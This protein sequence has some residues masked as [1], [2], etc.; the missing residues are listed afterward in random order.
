MSHPNLMD[1]QHPLASLLEQEEES[2]EGAPQQ[3]NSHP[4]TDLAALAETLPYH[5]HYLPAYEDYSRNMYD[6]P[7]SAGIM[8]DIWQP[9]LGF[10][11]HYTGNRNEVVSLTDHAIL[12][13]P[14]DDFWQDPATTTGYPSLSSHMVAPQSY[15][16]SEYG[17]TLP[18]STQEASAV[19]LWTTFQPYQQPVG[20]PEFTQRHEPQLSSQL[21]LDP[22]SFDPQYG[23]L[24][25]IY[26]SAHF[27]QSNTGL[28]P[29]TSP[30]Y[31]ASEFGPNVYYQTSLDPQ[32]ATQLQN[33]SNTLPPRQSDDVLLPAYANV[34]P[35]SSNVV[36]SLDATFGLPL[37]FLPEYLNEPSYH[38]LP[39]IQ[40]SPEVSQ[41]HS[42]SLDGPH[43]M[44]LTSPSHTHTTIN[45]TSGKR[46]CA[47]IAD[48]EHYI[49]PEIGAKRARMSTISDQEHNISQKATNRPLETGVDLD[50]IQFY[51]NPVAEK[52]DNK[53][54]KW[55]HVVQHKTDIA[56]FGCWLRKGRVGVLFC[57]IFHDLLLTR[58][59]CA[60]SGSGAC[61]SCRI[62]LRRFAHCTSVPKFTCDVRTNI[63]EILLSLPKLGIF[64][65]AGYQV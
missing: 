14:P 60:R 20:M 19:P 15:Q 3:S 22:N 21:S 55:S 25:N 27:Q 24:D 65:D 54:R 31:I 1:P 50:K 48:Q 61:E 58:I 63:S 45:E 33:S 8:D 32:G 37:P 56:C 42:Q 4:T 9:P 18:R 51:Q 44:I 30:L 36:A 6:L 47:F 62:I 35:A 38:M 40:P 34:P 13:D 39:Y 11:E 7:A 53:N 29:L 23:D 41:L 17:M 49:S 5:L 12:A 52:E 16:I 26:H 64:S 28:M 57:I 43:S 10:N 2:Q 59:Q 46:A